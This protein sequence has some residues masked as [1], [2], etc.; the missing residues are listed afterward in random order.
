MPPPPE[1]PGTR[2][3]DIYALGMVLYVISTGRGPAFFPE[4]SSTLVEQT[5][6]PDF[7]VLNRIITRACEPDRTQRYETAAQLLSELREAQK[8][9][10]GKATNHSS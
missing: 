4:L 6:H 5:S 1:P 7:V 2:Q 9:L 8:A 10:E 3:A